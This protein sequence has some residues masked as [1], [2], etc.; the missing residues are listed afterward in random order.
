MNSVNPVMNL[1][2]L[3]A[4]FC[5]FVAPICFCTSD[6]HTSAPTHIPVTWIWFKASHLIAFVRL[7]RYATRFPLLMIV[8]VEFITRPHSVTHTQAHT[9]LWQTRA[10]NF[11][12]ARAHTQTSA[13]T[14]ACRMCSRAP[15]SAGEIQNRDACAR[16]KRA[17]N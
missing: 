7:L 14:Y 12:S 15:Q 9:T 11:A 10:F 8:D 1:H 16:A 3:N 17:R 2:L 5:F 4:R 6:I 13:H